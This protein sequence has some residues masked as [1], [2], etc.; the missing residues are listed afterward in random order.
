M[1]DNYQFTKSGAP[2]FFYDI[3]ETVNLGELL[4][5]EYN[6]GHILFLDDK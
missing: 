2:T 1:I 6:Q 5:R 3:S 4:Y